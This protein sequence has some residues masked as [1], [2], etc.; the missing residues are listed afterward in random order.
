MTEKYSR[1]DRQVPVSAANVKCPLCD[2]NYLNTSISSLGPVCEDCGAVVSVAFDMDSIPDD[3]EQKS[4][5]TSAWSEYYRITNSTE[6]QIARAFEVLENISNQLS[7]PS[8]IRERAAE[9]YADGA[10]K[11]LTD[12]RSTEVFVSACITLAGREKQEPI[13]A[14]RIAT[15]ADIDVTSLRRICRELREEFDLEISACLPTEYLT[16]LTRALEL[17]NAT[18]A[19]AIRI[20]KSLPSQRTGGKHPAAIAGAALYLASE[21]EVTQRDVARATE[22]TTE[23]IRLR[24]NECRETSDGEYESNR[25]PRSNQ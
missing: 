3:F 19:T 10:T 1:Q 9:I 16:D 7:I 6:Q 11:T 8:S 22:V 17:E 20:L 5:A 14:D 24:V 18:R 21:G 13:P 15:K 4:E 23:T 12:G 2:S 25:S